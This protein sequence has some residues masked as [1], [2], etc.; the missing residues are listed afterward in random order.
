MVARCDWALTGAGAS[1]LL[2][3]YLTELTVLELYVDADR[4]EDPELPGRL[5]CREVAKG[6]VVELRALLAPMS[7]S[8][9][10]VDGV[11][12]AL[13]ARVYADLIAAGG[14]LAEAGHHLKGVRG[15]GPGAE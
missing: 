11:Q 2:A 3:P 6:H 13:P 7:A 12:V 5:G 4:F 14:R 15:V 8:G 10:K 1:M 9:P